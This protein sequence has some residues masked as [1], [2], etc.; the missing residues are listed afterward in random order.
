MTFKWKDDVRFEIPIWR[1]SAYQHVEATN[2]IP[3]RDIVSREE[4]SIKDQTLEKPTY[5]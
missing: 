5:K 2:K 4:E 1:T 3:Q